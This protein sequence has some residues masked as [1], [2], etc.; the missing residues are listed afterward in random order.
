MVPG[1]QNSCHTLCNGGTQFL[2]WYPAARIPAVPYAVEV[3][4]FSAGTQHSNSCHTLCS[5]GPQFLCWYGAL[6]FLPY[7]MQWRSPVSL[8]VRSTQIPAIPYAMEVPSFSAGTRQPEFLPYLMQWRY[9]VSLLVPGSQ[10]SDNPLSCF[11]QPSCTQILDHVR[12]A[13]TG[14]S[15]FDFCIFYSTKAKRTLTSSKTRCSS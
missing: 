6:K 7:L 15:S 13:E 2:C 9:P 1:S 8:L 4:S 5:G 10:N 14:F 12:T 11:T 3:P